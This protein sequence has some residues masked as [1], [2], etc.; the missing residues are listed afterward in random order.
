ME[1]L[2]AKVGRNFSPELILNFSNLNANLEG[3]L[4]S[5]KIRS[6][7]PLITKRE[8]IFHGIPAEL[9]VI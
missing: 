3:F 9:L 1:L 7:L 8:A 2:K 4:K 5:R 6:I